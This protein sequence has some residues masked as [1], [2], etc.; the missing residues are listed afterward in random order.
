MGRLRVYRGTIAA[1]TE[2]GEGWSRYEKLV[3]HR[4]D[5]VDER[6]EHLEEA[7]VLMRIE[8]AQRKVKAGLWG[9]L[10]GAIPATVAIVLSW[11]G[12]G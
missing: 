7:V 6:L 2:D 8:L 9:A 11:S 10:A 4:L 1:V 5:E 12:A 3:I